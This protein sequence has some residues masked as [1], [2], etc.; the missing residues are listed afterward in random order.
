MG[1]S[2]A[3]VIDDLLA[4]NDIRKLIMLIVVMILKLSHSDNVGAVSD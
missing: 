3:V 4:T 1:G 2:R